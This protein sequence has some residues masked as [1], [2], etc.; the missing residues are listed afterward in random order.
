MKAIHLKQFPSV[1]L[2]GARSFLSVQKL[3]EVRPE[4]R[5]QISSALK[6]FSRAISDVVSPRQP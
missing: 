4:L 6:R 5:P 2:G 3:W 1:A